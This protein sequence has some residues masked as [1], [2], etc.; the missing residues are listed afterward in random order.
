M[1][2]KNRPKG[3]DQI[4]LS[5]KESRRS[6]PG[7]KLAAACLAAT[8]AY[9]VYIGVLSVFVLI[10]FFRVSIRLMMKRYWLQR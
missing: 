5:T 9:A 8:V 6:L 10:A 4:A 2:S 7:R 3:I 1:F